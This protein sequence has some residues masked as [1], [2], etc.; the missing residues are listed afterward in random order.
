MTNSFG[1]PP[2]VD[3]GGTKNV[4]RMISLLAIT[5][6]FIRSNRRMDVNSVFRM[7]SWLD[8]HQDNIQNT[9]NAK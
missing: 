9:V 2:F 8:S 6:Q 1:P 3:V 5:S 4:K 7:F